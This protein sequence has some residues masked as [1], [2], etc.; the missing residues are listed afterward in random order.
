M[1]PHW[2][3][4]SCWSLWI[5]Y[6]LWLV[7]KKKNSSASCPG[8]RSSYI[9]EVPLFMVCWVANHTEIRHDAASLPGISPALFS[10]FLTPAVTASSISRRDSFA[11]AA[12]P[13]LNFCFPLTHFL[14]RLSFIPC[15]L[16]SF[17]PHLL[18]P[19][20]FYYTISHLLSPY[21]PEACVYMCKCVCVC[22]GR[23]HLSRMGYSLCS[24]ESGWMR[25]SLSSSAAYLYHSLPTY[26]LSTNL[27][28]LSLLPHSLSHG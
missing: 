13:C 3:G 26:R 24:G 4:I 1:P 14:S 19:F 22:V 6:Q 25:G 5:K 2:N 15:F 9:P 8:D 28:I 23:T 7:N 16:V 20:Y 21:S 18:S 17:S 12:G 10:I 11:T 27:Q